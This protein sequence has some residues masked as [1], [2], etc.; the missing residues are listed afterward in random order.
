MFDP[1][2][3]GHAFVGVGQFLITRA[4]YVHVNFISG[5]VANL[6]IH[7]AWE[8]LENSSL[9]VAMCKR[10]ELGY[11]GDALI[12]SV[13]DVMCFGVGYAVAEGLSHM[14][15]W[16]PFAWGGALFVAHCLFWPGMPLSPETPEERTEYYRWAVQMCQCRPL[17]ENTVDA[18]VDA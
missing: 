13:G 2:S 12:N 18:P 10:I 17:G 16:Q 5:F 11:D 4:S 1:W 7:I 8:L 15:E 14:G 9:F 3:F 6:L